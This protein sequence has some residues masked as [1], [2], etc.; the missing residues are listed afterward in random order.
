MQDHYDVL[1]IGS[2]FAGS[3][4]ADKLTQA[5][6][7]VAMIERGPWRDTI[8]TQSAG[9]VDR[10]SFP[11]GLGFLPRFLR[12]IT[13]P[14]I[15]GTILLNKK[16]L[17]DFYTSKGFSIFCSSCVG[18]GSNVYTALHN[19]PHDADY[20]ED[21]SKHTS[22][23]SMDKHYDACF[24]KM[25]SRAITP[26]DN[27]PNRSKYD[28]DEFFG[29]DDERLDIKM[30][31]LFP[32]TPGSPSAQIDRNKIKRMET[33]YGDDS[34]FGS[35]D[36]SKTTLDTAY[37]HD[38]MDRGMVL[39]DMT[40]VIAIYSLDDLD[41]N[42]KVARFRVDCKDFKSGGRKSLFANDIFL[43][44]GMFNTLKLL[45]TSSEKYKGIDKIPNL[46]KSISGNGDYIAYWA[47]KGKDK[48]YNAGPP[49]HGPLYIKQQKDCPMFI[50]VGLAFLDRVPIIRWLRRR[51]KKHNLLVGMGPDEANGLFTYR[52]GK[53]R[54]KYDHDDNP[55]FEKMEESR[56][57]LSKHYKTPV[58]K[59]PL[60]LTVHPF[61]GAR[62]G[63]DP[64]DSVVNG[65]GEMHTCPGLYVVDAAAFPKAIGA[66]PS[67][68][69]AAWSGHV[70]ENYINGTKSIVSQEAEVLAIV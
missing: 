44:A 67:M 7:K 18:G 46:G 70:A 9:I 31:L 25:G 53:F 36:G 39:H 56:K 26:A 64:A 10:S 13:L 69:I 45:A 40:E 1:V 23:S 68:S 5:G 15:K 54:I 2:G 48:N 24:K 61:G 49:A 4:S 19:R 14:F 28:N 8:P 43:G 20:W 29:V 34:L 63:D 22:R 21:V 12:S 47:D 16:G 50:V 37:L 59:F 3:V 32:E 11:R 27:V 33:S 57:A 42:N 65:L 52:N 66:P 55:I 51:T 38:C 58:R 60:S 35:Y 30:G 41:G 62:I 6:L 17:Y